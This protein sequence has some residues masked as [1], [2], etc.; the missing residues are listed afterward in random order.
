MMCEKNNMKIH[1]CI[2]SSFFDEYGEEISLPAPPSKL[3]VDNNLLFEDNLRK[4]DFS[5]IEKLGGEIDY[6]QPF[7]WKKLT[8]DVEVHRDRSGWSLLY[9]GAGAGTFYY[10][11]EYDRVVEVPLTSGFFICFYDYLPH[12]FHLNSPSCSVLVVGVKKRLS[13]KKLN[14]SCYFLG[15]FK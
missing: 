9:V 4:S 3:K 10:E 13:K 7:G 5:F 14:D 11:P 1:R 12:A 6:K 8:Q 2:G 15:N